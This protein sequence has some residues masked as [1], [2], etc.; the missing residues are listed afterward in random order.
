[1]KVQLIALGAT[2]VAVFAS[3]A[4]AAR[5]EVQMR[6]GDVG[7]GVTLTADPTIV[8]W[9]Q[10][11]HLAGGTVS[12]RAGERVVV[13]VKR[14][15]RQSFEAATSVETTADG[16]WSSYIYVGV[17][18]VFRATWKGEASADVRVRQRPGVVLI[19][20]TAARFEVFVNANEYVTGKSVLLQRYLRR[21]G[22]WTNVKSAV[23]T[24]SGG[25]R[26]WTRLQP[27]LPKRTLVRAVFPLP[28]ARPCYLAGYS[29]L[30]RT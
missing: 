12:G 18:S 2:L 21:L 4:A 30:V 26:T 6:L 1:M 10:L 5:A 25:G 14:C 8:R 22:R 19:Q 27:R 23:L 17:N 9:Y 16:Q 7:P 13:H 15:G 20:R 3:T 28:Q 29:N 24:E 11:V